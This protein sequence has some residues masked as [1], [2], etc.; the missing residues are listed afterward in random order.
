MASL[1]R[2]SDEEVRE[3]LRRDWTVTKLS[4]AFAWVI[5]GT[6]TAYMVWSATRSGIGLLNADLLGPSILAIAFF[7]AIPAVMT[8]V[9]W[10]RRKPTLPR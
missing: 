1:R 8:V 3:V 10:R 4:I 5:V 7:W 6:M 2:P 9:T